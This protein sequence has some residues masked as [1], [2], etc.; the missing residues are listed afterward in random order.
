MGSPV[1]N[2]WPAVEEGNAGKPR[3]TIS[4]CLIASEAPRVVL[5]VESRQRLRS[6]GLT[7]RGAIVSAHELWVGGARA[8]GL[9]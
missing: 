5:W 3:R 8:T 1:L 4:L 6:Q 2:Q 7:V 9:T